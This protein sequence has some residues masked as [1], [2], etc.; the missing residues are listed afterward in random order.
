MIILRNEAENEEK[1]YENKKKQYDKAD[2]NYKEAKK[3]YDLIKLEVEELKSKDVK[4]LQEKLEVDLQELFKNPISTKVSLN[5]AVTISKST[6]I[7][8]HPNHVF[9]WRNIDV[10]DLKLLINALENEDL[11]S[12]DVVLPLDVKSVLENLYVPHKLDEEQVLISEKVL[13]ALLVNLG[14]NK[15]FKPMVINILR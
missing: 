2:E 1:K 13:K 10:N 14:Y 11:T 12:S 3:D 9:F 6:N 5:D 15:G 8:L 7:P 4:G